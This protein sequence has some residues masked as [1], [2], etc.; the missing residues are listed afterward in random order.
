MKKGVVL[1]VFLFLFA[2]SE[3]S[4]LP[5]QTSFPPSNP[6]TG[7]LTLEQK[8]FIAEFEY[9]VYGRETLSEGG[10]TAK[11]KGGIRIF[12]DGTFNQTFSENVSREL[13]VLNTFM[14]DGTS[15]VLAETLEDADIHLFVGT[16]E[17]LE[18]LWNDIFVI[19]QRNN[20]GGYAS[21]NFDLNDLSIS[22]GRI[23]MINQSTSLLIHEIGHILGL[24]HS[25]AGFC[26]N[27]SNASLSFMCPAALRQ[28]YS[29][30]DSGIIRTLYHPDIPIGEPFETVE[31]I[32]RGLLQSEVIKL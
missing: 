29:K 31:P 2:C 24:G 20:F 3:E 30:F 18:V 5:P 27:N 22:G 9:K 4:G 8:Q 13:D 32:V 26:Q 28:T 12:L 19:V 10:L 6:T 14:T 25:S 21:T 16:L 7:L 1:G 17:E 11:L 15:L 23:Y